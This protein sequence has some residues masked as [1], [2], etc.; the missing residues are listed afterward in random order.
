MLVELRLAL[1]RKRIVRGV[2]FLANTS[3][4]TTDRASISKEITPVARKSLKEIP[5]KTVIILNGI[6]VTG[7]KSRTTCS[8]VLLGRIK[9]NT[10]PVLK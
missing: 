6:L 3:S 5:Q 8:L 10:V 4:H 7:H 9:K 1:A 2:F